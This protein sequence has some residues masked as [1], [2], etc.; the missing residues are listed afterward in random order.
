MDKLSQHILALS[1][2]ANYCGY[3]NGISRHLAEERYGSTQVVSL[4]VEGDLGPL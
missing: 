4:S 3:E 1:R 2:L